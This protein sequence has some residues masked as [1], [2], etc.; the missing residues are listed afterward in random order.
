MQDSVVHVWGWEWQGGD[1]AGSRHYANAS[2]QQGKFS[3]GPEG[4]REGLECEC[5][6][7]VGLDEALWL[8]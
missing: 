5:W 2:P 4:E 7:A 1:T 3:S 8:A 6:R